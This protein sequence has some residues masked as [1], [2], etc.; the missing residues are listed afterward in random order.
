MLYKSKLNNQS[1]NVEMATVI[2]TIEIPYGAVRYR[3]IY[4]PFMMF[5]DVVNM[6]VKRRNILLTAHDVINYQNSTYAEKQMIVIPMHV[7]MDDIRNYLYTNKHLIGQ[8]WTIINTPELN[9]LSQ[10][11]VDNVNNA[12]W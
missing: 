11:I 2:A 6:L 7:C 8:H 9:V 1:A 4:G 10:I 5:D 12:L 3:I